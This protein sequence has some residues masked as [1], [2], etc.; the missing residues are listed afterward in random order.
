MLREIER[1][2][3]NGE[4]RVERVPVPLQYSWSPA[5]FA[6]IMPTITSDQIVDFGCLP[7]EGPQQ[8]FT[9]TF[10]ATTF[11]FDGYVERNETVR[12][13]LEI[14]SDQFASSTCQVFE[15]SWDGTWTDQMDDMGRHLRIREIPQSGSR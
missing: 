2:G 3:P 7:D 14:V 11:S 1:P 8:R 13:H 12:Y 9:P 10:Y 5:E 4:W 15:V 6:P